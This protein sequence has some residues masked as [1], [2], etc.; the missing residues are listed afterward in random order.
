MASII[1]HHQ[2]TV[3]PLDNNIDTLEP[4]LPLLKRLINRNTVDILVAHLYGRQVNMDP[5]ISVA[6][7]YNLDIIEDCAESFSGFVHI[8]HPDS[9]LAL[10]SFGVIKFSTSFGGNIIKV[11][12][13]ELYRQM[14][15]LYL[16]YPIQSNATYLKKLLKY[17]P[18]YTTLQVWPFPQLMQKSR[19]MGMDWKAT[20][21]C[22]LRGFPND[23]IN[24]VRYR[25]S[26]ALLSVMAGV[27]TSFNPASFD[28]Q[29]IKCSYFQSNLTTS[30]KV[31]G[32]KTKIN[33]FWLFP[34]VVENPELFVRCLG[35][36]GV[37]A[38]RGATQLNVIEPDQV[39]LPS[40]P[41]I[42]GEIV[43]P[44]DR[45]PLNARYLIDHVVYMPVNKFVPFHVIDHMA[46]VCKLVMLAMSSP[47]KQAFDL[48]RSLTKSKGMSL[49][50][51]K[52]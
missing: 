21:V 18:L 19:E 27:Q 35:A 3:V 46:K 16:K 14:H 20:F 49:V 15:E 51:S 43:P 6:R 37:D 11:R 23:L 4:K 8:G 30:L 52:L 44:E 29:R 12:E 40:Q 42:V 9:D 36:L 32:T 24:N 13:E 10:F 25:P 2:L 45:Y 26:S 28:L 34:V 33:N 5:F 48:C 22:F 41:N 38:Y 47:P 1:R 39:D 7:Y 31:I 17:F 50:K